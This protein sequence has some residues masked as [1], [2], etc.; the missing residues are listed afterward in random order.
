MCIAAAHTQ[1]WHPFDLRKWERPEAFPQRFSDSGSSPS[2]RTFPS[3]SREGRTRDPAGEGREGRH[4]YRQDFLRTAPRGQTGQT[5]WKRP[6]PF[7]MPAAGSDRSSPRDSALHRSRSAAPTFPLRNAAARSRR[8]TH[9]PG[10]HAEK[11]RS[12]PKERP[13][14]EGTF[15][16]EIPI[17]DFARE[18]LKDSRARRLKLAYKEHGSLKR[19]FRDDELPSRNR[20]RDTPAKTHAQNPKPKSNRK[21]LNKAK[22]D[23]F[24]PSTV[25][26][27]NL[28]RILG[29][30][31]GAPDSIPD[32]HCLNDQSGRL[33]RRMREAGMAEEASYDHG[34]PVCATSSFVALTFIPSPDLRVCCPAGR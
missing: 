23:V 11:V 19:A 30:S 2:S 9:E 5:K 24:I 13:D 18:A 29:V 17:S 22:V 3:T 21:A 12:L 33:Q 28:A 31:L 8:E 20:N 26:V 4:K 15:E 27:G 10:F 7:P 1:P 14:D 32:F 34:I 25:S 16:S 6:I